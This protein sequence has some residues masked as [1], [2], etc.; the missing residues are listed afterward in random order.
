MD[1]TADIG[2][3]QGLYR[4]G[5]LKDAATKCIAILGKDGRHFDALYLL[6]AIKLQMQA[7]AEARRLFEQAAAV[8]PDSVEVLTNL[9]FVLLSLDRPDEAL[10]HADGALKL[11]PTHAGAW[12]TRGHALAR[13]DR[14]DD[15]LASIDHAI[16]TGG[17]SVEAL[18]ARGALLVRLGQPADAVATFDRLPV[19]H[20]PAELAKR[21][22]MQRSLGLLDAA[23]RDY[24]RLVELS[25]QA[26]PGWVGLVLCAT[27]SCDWQG[28]AEPRRRVLAAVDAGQ[29]VQ[30]LLVMQ[31]SSDPAQHLKAARA[32]A[33]GVAPAA[34]A[35][36]RRGQRPARLRIAYLSPD[37]RI[38]PLAFLIVELLERHDRSRFEVVGV[39]LTPSDRSEIGER[40]AKSFDHFLD[41][42]AHSDEEIVSRLRD[43][44][45]D[46]AIDLAGYT[47][48]SRPGVLARRI[49]PIQANYLGYCGTSGSNFIDYLLV[50]QVAVPP[51]QQKFFTEK[52]VYL[53]DSFMAAD[54]SQAI[55]AETPS[56]SQCELPEQGF[57]FCCFNKNYKITRP[58]YEIWMRLLRAV[59]G[60]VLW[61]SAN[62]DRGRDNLGRHAARM[63]VD[64]QR[65]VFA[66]ALPQRAD[67][68]ARQRLADLFL[69]T[70]PYNAHTSASDALFAGLPVLT[71]TGPTFVG[72]VAA[73]ML[74]AIGLPEL[75]AKDLEEY[76][77]LA[78]D[79]ALD[80][81][82]LQAIRSKLAA[83]RLSMPLFDTDR[84][85][86]NIEAAYDRMFEI[87]RK[88]EQ[89]MPFS[90]GSP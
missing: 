39:S 18:I 38:H 27:E 49:A 55:S 84:L 41:L 26:L 71:A 46:I 50:D 88:G 40:I 78:L 86:Q 24:R 60:S 47:D 9:A 80:P 4:Q 21:A 81:A 64:P 45:I 19:W 83:N 6:A 25:P 14:L 63:G 59:D 23:A 66:P 33:P 72:R 2:E 85:R 89:P 5:R 31:I 37:F 57:V 68:L 42:S 77:V 53:P 82:R 73:S 32:V 17:D 29:P 67:H 69:D 70:L 10:A 87:H 74:H 28:L 30:P 76:E 22:N 44:K 51:E 43:L 61:L 52:L 13:L 8:R 16:K 48:Q 56:R 11:A 15:A 35:F 65:I 75:I 3:A 34:P 36:T 58:A 54:S 79:L 90:V 1:W 62:L 20:K 7:P 12:V